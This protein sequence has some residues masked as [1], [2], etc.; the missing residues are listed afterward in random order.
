MSAGEDKGE[1]FAE[2]PSSRFTAVNEKHQPTI[3]VSM[4]GTSGNGA[5]RR[6]LPD[7]RAS[8]CKIP[9]PPKEKLS[10]T[11][12][13]S[14]THSEEWISLYSPYGSGYRHMSTH[15]GPKIRKRAFSH[16]TKTGCMTCRRRKKNCDEARPECKWPHPEPSRSILS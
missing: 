10:I 7:E 6:S 2:S 12:S 16:R 3:V 11:A 9:P 15:A 1:P 5:P 14:P 4:N 8:W 13:T